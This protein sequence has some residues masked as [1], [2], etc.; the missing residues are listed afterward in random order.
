MK[1]VLKLVKMAG[2]YILEY[3]PP[4]P[5]KGEIFQ[6]NLPWKGNQRNVE[7]QLPP[8]GIYYIHIV[9]KIVKIPNYLLL[10]LCI[11]PI[12]TSLHFIC[13]PS[14]LVL[15]ISNFMQKIW[16]RKPK[17]IMCQA[18]TKFQSQFYYIQNFALS[19]GKT[20]IWI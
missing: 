16:G 12:L 17:N 7:S 5:W 13:I 6:T 9:T 19:K 15:K 8:L 4:P 11:F 3:Y 2:A 18:G 10:F 20:Q 1:L 14:T